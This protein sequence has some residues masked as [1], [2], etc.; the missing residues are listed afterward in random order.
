MHFASDNAGPVHP[1]VLDALGRANDGYAMPYGAEAAM[2]DLRS[3][4]RDLFEAPKAAIYLVA[5]GTAA[6]ALLLASLCQPWQRIYCADVAHIEED[7]CGAPEFFTNAAKLSL[8]DSP[9]GLMGT[10]ALAR[11]GAWPMRS[12][13]WDA[14]LPR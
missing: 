14:R 10:D 7:E 2:D 3:R 11:A 1:S 13:R 6:N 9:D 8:T 4:L 5:T 12:R